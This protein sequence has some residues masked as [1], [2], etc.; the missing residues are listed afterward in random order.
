MHNNW[1]RLSVFLF[2]RHVSHIERHLNFNQ[3]GRID[4][5]RTEARGKSSSG[6]VELGE[7]G[8]TLADT[9]LAA[10]EAARAAE[11]KLQSV[12]RDFQCDQEEAEHAAAEKLAEAVEEG[13]IDGEPDSPVES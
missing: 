6:D 7:L 13:S 11:A 8:K 12:L 10:A 9:K 5:K 2:V 3:I 1:A 4:V